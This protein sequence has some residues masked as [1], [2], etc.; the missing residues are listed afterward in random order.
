MHFVD[1]LEDFRL[2]AVFIVIC[3]AVIWHNLKLLANVLGNS[4]YGKTK[5]VLVTGCDSGFGLSIA[6]DLTES[7]CKVFAGCLTQEG[8]ERLEKNKD[9]DGFAFLMDVTKNEDIEKAR[10]FIE[11]KTENDGENELFCLLLLKFFVIE[12]FTFCILSAAK[13][14]EVPI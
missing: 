12:I 9:F 4:H 8:V 3:A 2:V 5:Y 11:E 13:V 6:L 10:N 7:K 1:F 14:F